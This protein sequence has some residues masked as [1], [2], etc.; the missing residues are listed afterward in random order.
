[1]FASKTVQFDLA[2][3]TAPFRGSE[4]RSND[5]LNV[6]CLVLHYRRATDMKLFTKLVPFFVAKD[7]NQMTIGYM[8]LFAEVGSATW[9]IETPASTNYYVR[10]ELLRIYQEEIAP[11][12]AY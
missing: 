4:V 11:L 2:G 7:P 8:P 6:Y 9:S 1:M 3:L 5:L 12:D 10:Q